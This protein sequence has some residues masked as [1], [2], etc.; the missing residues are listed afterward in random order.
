MGNPEDVRGSSVSSVERAV[1][2]LQVLRRLGAAAVSEIAAEVGLHKSTVSRLLSTLEAR[3]MVEQSGSRGRYRLGYGVAQIA[4]GVA[5]RH[6]LTVIARPVCEELARTVGETVN[7]VVPDGREVV[8][9]DQV[10]GASAVT[11]VNWVGQRNPLHVTSAGKVFLAWLPPER[12]EEVLSDGLQRYT[13]HTVVDPSE[14]RAQLADVRRRGYGS[15]RDEYEIGLAAVAAPIRNADGEVVAAVG[16]SGPT[17][18]LDPTALPAMAGR[19]VAAAAEISERNG[20][21]RA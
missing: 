7:I 15:T 11:T 17:F 19:V 13:E 2:V 1:A 20:S 18:R 10:I 16:V 9:I 12:L 8:S 4:A 5:G 6:D 14:L 3:G 21:P